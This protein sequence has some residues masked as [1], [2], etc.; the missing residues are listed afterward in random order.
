MIPLGET[1]DIRGWY[2]YLAEECDLEIGQDWCWAWDH[3]RNCWAIEFADPKN[4]SFF[5]L[6]K[7]Q[8]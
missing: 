4:E 7:L 5:T 6:I 3:D 1:A 2:R 8:Q